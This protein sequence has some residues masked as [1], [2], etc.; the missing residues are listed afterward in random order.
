MRTWLLLSLV[1]AAL[2]APHL[3]LKMGGYYDRSPD[4]TAEM[5]TAERMTATASG[6]QHQDSQR[7]V[8]RVQGSSEPLTEDFL[9]RAIA[10][11]SEE[12]SAYVSIWHWRGIREATAS[13]RGLD[14]K[15]HFANSYLVGFQPFKTRELWVPLYTLATRKEYQ[16]DHLQYAGLADIWQTSRQA[17]FQKRGD[18]EDHAILLADWLI[19][20]GVD[21]R[22]AMGTLKG[23]GHAWVVAIVNNREYLLEA[24]S[25]RRQ[26]SWQAMPLAALAEG[27]EVEFQFN[28]HFFWAKR[29]KEPTRTYRGN[30]WVKKSQFIRG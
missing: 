20:L 22:V 2:M 3:A 12:D 15:H 8:V 6:Q 7:G 27:Y 9:H 23:E 14:Q 16:Y 29:S 30:H 24:T 1:T 26:S 5:L 13:A 18:C 4:K 19:N 17:F 10:T 28:R 21:A 11:R 25:K